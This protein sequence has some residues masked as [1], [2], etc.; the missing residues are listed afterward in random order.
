M[1]LDSYGI[2][3]AQARAR[4]IA[5]PGE[6]HYH[7][8]LAA[9]GVNYRAAINVRSK[10]HPSE[11]A[12][13]VSHHLRHPLTR[14]LSRLRDGFHPLPRTEGGL[15]FDFIR[16]NLFEP[17][18]FLV[19]PCD[20]PLCRV[21]LNEVFDELILPAIGQPDARVYIYGEPWEAHH[22]SDP[23][24]RFFP[25]RGMHEIH[26][27]QGNDPSH[28]E[29]DGTWQDGGMLIHYPAEHRW[30]G[31]FLKFQSQSWHTDDFT[32]H[33]LLPPPHFDHLHPVPLDR[34]GVPHPDGMVRIHSARL[35]RQNAQG[36]WEKP[37]IA[38]L[39]VCP[40]PVELEGW[41]LINRSKGRW[42]LQGRLEAGECREFPIGRTL[43]L[44]AEGGL[45]T[46]LNAEGLKVHGVS[47]TGNG[48]R[49]DELVFGGLE[50]GASGG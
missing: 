28:W 38:L 22:G 49:G 1:P 8:H 13:Y 26:M 19:L 48:D 2:L 15:A 37:V 20:G 41:R 27:N 34:R 4:R 35:A 33:A 3:K 11:V 25:S 36:R 12:Y 18:E 6:S 5:R 9:H 32:G 21:D 45:I 10:L 16:T 46:L 23:I 47:Y 31:V 30:R 39:N 42:K 50:A 17:T 7:L 40:Y 24:F 44:P 43:P 14:E 29:Q